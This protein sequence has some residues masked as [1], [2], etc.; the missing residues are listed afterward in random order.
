MNGKTIEIE[1]ESR[2]TIEGSEGE[3]RDEIRHSI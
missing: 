2:D 1:A 3:D